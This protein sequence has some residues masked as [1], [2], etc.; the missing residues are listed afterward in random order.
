[1]NAITTFMRKRL[2]PAGNPISAEDPR[3]RDQIE[4]VGPQGAVVYA[5]A[6]NGELMALDFLNSITSPGRT[7][8]KDAR[9]I[10]EL[11]KRLARNGKI[12]NPK[13]FVRER[14][15]IWG[16]KSHQVRIGAFQHGRIW[17][18]T[19]GFIKKCDKWPE[20]E[21]NR[22]DEIRVQQLKILGV[23]R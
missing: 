19:H 23:E 17:F 5:R 8:L 1:M 9:K 7:D 11:C 4:I 22:A 16:L 6:A 3:L 10:R 13:N 18:L 12:P 14:G 20:A 2:R 15:E 21:L